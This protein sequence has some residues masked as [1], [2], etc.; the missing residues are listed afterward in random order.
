MK[1]R[2]FLSLT[3]LCA[4][5]VAAGAATPLY[6]VRALTEPVSDVILSARVPGQVARIHHA[7]GDFVKA[8]TVIL[9]FEQRS[10]LLEVQRKQVQKDTLQAELDRSELLF[11]TSNSVP[12]EE[13]ERK[14][15]EVEVAKVELAQAE[16]V[17]AHRRVVA[18]FDGVITLLSV[19]VGEYCELARPLAR[20]VDSREFDAVS[21]VDPARAGHLEAGQAIEVE[22]PGP[23]GAVVLPGRVIFVS[24]VVDP[25]SGLMR[26]KARFANPGNRVRPGV[27]GMLRIPS[28]DVP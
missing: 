5:A 2:G 16:E 19:K 24:S 25:A 6:Q 8:G 12:R 18:P 21:N 27:A 7:E 10:E 22:V 23:G 28:R 9:E 26:I 3:C 4:A 17:V 13:L 1:V 11:K 20:L 15:G 14:R